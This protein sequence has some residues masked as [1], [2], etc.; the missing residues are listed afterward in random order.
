M[1][2]NH[3]L[4]GL[5]L[6]AAALTAGAVS[7]QTTNPDPNALLLL[8]PDGADRTEPRCTIWKDAA[9]GEGLRV[10]VLS[11]S[12]FLALGASARQYRGVLLPD[13]IHQ[14]ASDTLVA[15][16]QS[17]VQAS[18]NLLLTFDENGISPAEAEGWLTDLS[19]FSVDYRTSR[20]I[21]FHPPGALPFATSVQNWMNDAQAMKSAGRFQW[22]TMTRLGNFLNA[23]NGVNWRSYRLADGSHLIQASHPTSLAEQT[24]VLPKSQYLRPVLYR[25]SAVI[26]EEATEWVVTVTRGQIVQFKVALTPAALR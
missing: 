16:L 1:F 4:S 14:R 6:A 12:E 5:L 19:H 25:G 13:Q 11:D 26:R 8:A 7:A 22:Y 3:L 10:L 17:Y 21:Y 2:R 15:S 20:M 24:W 18:G 23:R 9:T